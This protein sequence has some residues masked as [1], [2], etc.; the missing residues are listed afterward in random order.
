MG[1]ILV[2]LF[3][4]IPIAEL[5]V[6]IEVADVIGGFSTIGLL[7]LIGILGAIL[8]ARQGAGVWRQFRAARKRGEVPSRE[9]ADGFL[10]M[11]AAALLLTPGF[12]TDGLALI[13]LFPAT[14]AWVRR[15]LARTGKFLFFWRF[16][17]VGAA[18]EGYG[19]YRKVKQIT[20]DSRSTVP[21]K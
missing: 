1:A 13:L 4:V 3:I 7:L 16:P 19:K 18:K 2:V 9:I 21:P 5:I 20:S 17:A 11:L 15:Q 12:L 6:L 14:R 8:A 10:I